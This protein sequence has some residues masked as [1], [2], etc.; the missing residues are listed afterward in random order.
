VRVIITNGFQTSKKYSKN[1]P[2]LMNNLFQDVCKFLVACDKPAFGQ[3]K[4]LKP[5]LY[6]KF[7]CTW[8]NVNQY[9]SISAGNKI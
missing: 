9:G 7:S 5:S 6:I 8:K 1:V 4:N 3:K 2:L